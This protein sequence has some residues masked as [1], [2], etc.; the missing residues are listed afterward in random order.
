MQGAFDNL[1]GTPF[2]DALTGGAGTGVINGGG[3]NDVLRAGSG[4][5]V[6]VN[7]SGNSTLYG[8]SG[9]SLLIAGSGACTLYGGSGVSMLVG[10]STSYDANDQALLSILASLSRNA[11]AGRTRVPTS[12]S[13]PVGIGTGPY[14]LVMG[15]TVIDP[16]TDDK[17]VAGS[18]RTWFLP[19][20]H[21]TVKR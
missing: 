5:T 14:S 4:N 16:G 13:N 10:G 21:D 8:G 9:I 3:G 6:L 7:G 12:S 15:K 18:G 19:G 1:I 20:A 17:L 11:A 2:S